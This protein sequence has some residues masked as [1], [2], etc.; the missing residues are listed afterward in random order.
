MQPKMGGLNNRNLSSQNPGGTSP[1]SRL[2]PHKAC[3]KEFSMLLSLLLTICCPSLVTLVIGA[4]NQ[5]SAFSSDIL[6]EYVSAL[7]FSFF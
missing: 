7:N 5:F 1:R 4:S 3:G 2:V 6:V